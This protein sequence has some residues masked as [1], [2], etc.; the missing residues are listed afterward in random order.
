MWTQSTTRSDPTTMKDQTPL[1]SLPYCISP[2]ERPSLLLIC[3][4]PRLLVR[5]YQPFQLS[6]WRTRNHQNLL[7]ETVIN[8]ELTN[9]IQHYHHH[10]KELLFYRPLVAHSLVLVVHEISCALLVGKWLFCARTRRNWS[11]ICHVSRGNVLG[12]LSESDS[13]TNDANDDDGKDEGSL[14]FLVFSTQPSH[15][16]R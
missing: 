6:S 5:F 16:R 2:H 9:N 4:C 14:M 12:L 10:D 8:W 3:F 13:S 7:N 11:R 15:C 1:F